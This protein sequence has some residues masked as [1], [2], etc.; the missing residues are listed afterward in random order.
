[1][2]SR[3]VERLL[4]LLLPALSLVAGACDQPKSS[5]PDK[6]E[7]RTEPKPDAKPDTKPDTKPDAKPDA[8]PDTGA[9]T[10]ADGAGEEPQGGATTTGAAPTG[11][12]TTAETGQAGQ[13]GEA[14]RD[15]AGGD[16]PP[17][18][19]PDPLPRPKRPIRTPSCETGITCVTKA[20]AS[21]L[22]S[23]GSGSKMSCPAQLSRSHAIGSTRWPFVG[24]RA[25]VQFD[26]N[27]TKAKRDAGDASA[28]CYEWVGGCKGG[29]PLMDA[30][31]TPVVAPLQSG[32]AWRTAAFHLDVDERVGR[33]AAAQWLE[34]AAMEHASVASFSRVSLELMAL[35]APPDL[36][37]D[38]HAAALDEIRHAQT[39][40]AIAVAC[41]ASE[42]QPGPLPVCPPR[43]TDLARFAVDTF[44]EGCVGETTAALVMERAA[45]GTEHMALRAALEGIAG[46][47]ARHAALAWRT[48]AWA[49]RK[50]G[51]DVLRAVER[52]S[53]ALAPKDA[54]VAPSN[55]DPEMAAVGR[56]SAG[57]T[58]RARHDAWHG[59]IVPMLSRL[60]AESGVGST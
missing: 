28:C 43:P 6:G 54:R 38:T 48:L 35:G 53:A 9:E 47:E 60:I 41:G 40:L 25:T 29:R 26:E 55:V 36:L 20:E 7:V 19:P 17:D 1:M 33:A 52:T 59:L 12:T 39:C 30:S 31:A 11:A 37:A 2:P 5:D 16:P 8:K 23:K 21:K 15:S 24:G 57:E 50:G 42:V 49:V 56:L 18:P 14:G 4:R 22:A 58:N 45:A 3:D 32:A 13:G 34:D 27:E 46:D 51:V 44:I 10:N